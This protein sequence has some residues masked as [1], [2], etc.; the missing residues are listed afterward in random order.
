MFLPNS[1]IFGLE[2]STTQLRAIEI[3]RGL[4]STS[5]KA[6]NERPLS[7]SP[8]LKNGL[9]NKEELTKQLQ[10][11][12]ATAKPKPIEPERVTVSI[13]E[14]LVFSK[15]ITLPNV[16]RKEL[17]QTIP[18]E[19]AEFLPLPLEEMYL[20][21]QIEPT[22]HGKE[23]ELHVLVVAAP[24]GLVDDLIEVTK[25]AGLIIN[26]LESKSFA[27]AR[28]LQHH[29]T[30]DHV[31]VIANIG[32][33]ITTILFASRRAIKLTSTV[34]IAS[35]QTAAHIHHQAAVIADEINEGITY[36]HNRLGQAEPVQNIFLTGPGALTPHLAS[37]LKKL[38]NLPTEI[39]YPVI[40]LPNRQP[41]HPR[42]ST[43]LGL[44][45]R[46]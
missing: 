8:W 26:S 36:Y 27:L 24:R 5:V 30:D 17:N 23:A 40:Q 38:T 9:R 45:L 7:R 6:V 31:T 43:V 21:W 28:A 14:S 34:Q 37:R 16:S 18:F 44:A 15:V 25:G 4:F 46:D 39:G 3:E 1:R 42:F 19:A 20:D 2:I 33:K 41:I 35:G 32:H 12:L 29:L 13:P 11:L 10:E 22:G